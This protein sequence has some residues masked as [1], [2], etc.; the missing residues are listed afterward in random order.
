MSRTAFLRTVGGLDD[1]RRGDERSNRVWADARAVAQQAQFYAAVLVA[2]IMAWFLAKPDVF[3]TIPV[4]WIAALG[5]VVTSSYLAGR[6]AAIIPVWRRMTAP[7]GLLLM[8]LLA[9]WAVGFVRAIGGASTG[10]A[11]AIRF[12]IVLGIVIIG[13][14]VATYWRS[15]RVER[16]DDDLD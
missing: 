7:R 16:S 9:A 15:R 6:G 2:A 13:S 14:L 5:N 11:L 10:T 12:V 8:L 4:I 1:P 3:W